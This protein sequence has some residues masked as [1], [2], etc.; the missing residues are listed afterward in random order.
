MD[1][2]ADPNLSQE[3]LTQ[4]GIERLL[5]QVAEQ[6]NSVHIHLPDRGFNRIPK[7]AVQP[8]DFRHPT[9]LSP[10]ELRKLRLRHEEYLRSLAARL[11][12][13]LRLDFSL[14]MSKLQTIPFQKLIESFTNPTHLSLFKVEPLRGISVLELHPRLG[15]TIVDRL[16]GGPARSVASDHDLSE[17]ELALLDQAVQVFLTEWCTHWADIQDLQPVLLGHETNG[18]FLRS[19]P[20]DAIMLAL[21]MEARIGDCFEQIQI[22]FPYETLEPLIRQLGQSLEV[23]HTANL[24]SPRTPPPWNRQLDDLRLPVTAEWPGFELTLQQLTQLKPNDVLQ[25]SPHCTEQVTVRLA[26]LPK[27]KARLGT[28]A[29][30]W[31]LELTGILPTQT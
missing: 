7:D 6:E 25:L 24:Q 29:G 14:Q 13:F 16:L 23:N 30:H 15:L 9:F 21:S 3:V 26:D 5:A 2:A 22:A 11:S 12:V 8:Y 17:I 27:F 10:L 4:S 20:P 19:S 18:A 1:D 31:A 28:R